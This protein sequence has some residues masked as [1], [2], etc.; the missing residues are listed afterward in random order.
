MTHTQTIPNLIVIDKDWLD[1][2]IQKLVDEH[3]STNDDDEKS[4][5]ITKITL[6]Q[7]IVTNSYPLS[8]IVEDAWNKAVSIAT[9]NH[10]SAHGI[11]Y[12]NVDNEQ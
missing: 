5:C 7:F 1:K 8:S 2:E 4:Y 9:K 11:D 10:D 12:D 3:N 6:L